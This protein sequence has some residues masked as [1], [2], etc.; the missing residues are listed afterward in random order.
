MA[1]ADDAELVE[2]R[3]LAIDG[4]VVEHELRVH[5]Q[6]TVRRDEEGVDLAHLG[7]DALVEGVHLGHDIGQLVNVGAGEV[8]GEELGQLPDGIYRKFGAVGRD[9]HLHDRLGPCACHLFDVDSPGGAHHHHVGIGRG[10]H[11]GAYVA[12]ALLLG[13][14]LHGNGLYR[15]AL[16]TQREELGDRGLGLFGGLG[17]LD[18]ASLPPAAHKHHRLNHDRVLDIQRPELL[19]LVDDTVESGHLDALAHEHLLCLVLIKT[20]G[21]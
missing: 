10:I 20:H 21:L 7:I 15:V 18:P 3:L 9:G 11:G 6:R 19:G 17:P 16:D 2:E 5:G 12:G 1:H 4:I 8:L 14:G 13:H